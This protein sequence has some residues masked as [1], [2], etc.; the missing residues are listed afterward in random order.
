MAK[1]TVMAQM[2]QNLAESGVDRTIRALKLGSVNS[3]SWPRADLNSD[4]KSDA[5][6][7]LQL[8]TA[9]EDN[10]NVNGTSRMALLGYGSDPNAKIKT[11]VAEG[12]VTDAL[13][14]TAVRQIRLELALQSVF[15][16]G[17]V[18]KDSVDLSGATVV[19][20]YDSAVGLYDENVAGY[21]GFVGTLATTDSKLN[22]ASAEMR[23]E[24]ATGGGSVAF[25]GAAKLKPDAAT[26]YTGAQVDAAA[27][28]DFEMDLP[29]PFVPVAAYTFVAPVNGTSTIDSGAYVLDS[30]ALGN[31]TLTINGPDKTILVVL[32]NVDVGNGKIVLQNGAKVELYVRG[33]FEIG[34]NGEVNAGG[35]PINFQA[36]GIG[37]AATT[38]LYKFAGTTA[39]CMAVYAPNA[40]AD[41]KGTDG[42]RGA[43]IAKTVKTTGAYS[44]I[45]DES[46]GR[47]LPYGG[48]YKVQNYTEV[49]PGESNYVKFP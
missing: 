35:R 11:L 17:M 40:A 36:Y 49:R 13:G 22:V 29:T 43:I 7:T 46:L 47:E 30:I 27:K 24:I 48:N 21:K 14:Q 19:D 6:H 25:N 34:G 5:Y 10:G 26:T 15:Q 18:G 9:A 32:G 1:A 2:A 38:A 45:Y 39:S 3:T 42:L 23:G 37:G 8:I 33:D 12:A 28:K 4:G 20:S 41:L 44:F 16:Y 31:G